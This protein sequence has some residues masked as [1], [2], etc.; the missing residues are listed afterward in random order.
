MQRTHN[1][2]RLREFDNAFRDVAAALE[3]AQRD[4]ALGGEAGTKLDR[5]LF[6]LLSAITRFGPFG[7]VELAERVGRDYTTV[8][9][10]VARLE[11]LG[12]VKRREKANDLRV[13]EVVVSR[14]GKAMAERVSAAR[15]RVAAAVFES[16]DP[17]EVTVL[18]LLMRRFAGAL[19]PPKPVLES[20]SAAGDE[21]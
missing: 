18:A 12:L 1:V 10:Q 20:D 4:E 15:E 9:R 21:G 2:N 5:A 3:K 6:P 13:H 16:W 19:Q 17:K 7:V 8:S 14:S 11:S